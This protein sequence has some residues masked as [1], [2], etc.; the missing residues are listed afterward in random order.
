MAYDNDKMKVYG[1]LIR[2]GKSDEISF[3]PIQHK[4]ITKFFF[5]LGGDD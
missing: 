4:L 1:A 2:P 5:T 3:D